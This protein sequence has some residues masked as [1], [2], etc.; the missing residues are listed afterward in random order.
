MIPDSCPF[1]VSDQCEHFYIVLNFPFGLCTSPSPFP[2]QR[3]YS[4]TVDQVDAEMALGM[5]LCNWYYLKTFYSQTFSFEL[6]I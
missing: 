6:I 5:A 4:I 3:E 1:S 2:V